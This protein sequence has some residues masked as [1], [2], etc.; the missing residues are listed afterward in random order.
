[1]SNYFRG[2]NIFEYVETYE[3]ITIADVNNAIK[4]LIKKEF[5]AV[6]VVKPSKS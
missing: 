3:K 1:M 2:V 5:M 4:D 6:S